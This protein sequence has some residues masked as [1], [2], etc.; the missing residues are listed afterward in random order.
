MKEIEQ[1]EFDR[2][3]ATLDKSFGRPTLEKEEVEVEEEEKEERMDDIFFAESRQEQ[4][5]E[6]VAE[7][8]EQTTQLKGNSLNVE[9][10]ERENEGISKTRNPNV[11]ASPTKRATAPKSK[12]KK[13]FT[14]E[15][16]RQEI[17]KR[18][19]EMRRTEIDQV[20]WQP[21]LNPPCSILNQQ[22]PILNQL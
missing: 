16:G 10:R 12:T 21:T 7:F 4:I 6:S 1:A 22:W 15:E 8:F 2:L 19:M 13:S 20:M 11:P 9:Q 17:E 5:K 3:E 14:L 18:L